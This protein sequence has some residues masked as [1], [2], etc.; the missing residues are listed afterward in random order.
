MKL[1]LNHRT[2]KNLFGGDGE[3]YLCDIA[4]SEMMHEKNRCFLTIRL[5]QGA[6]LGIHQHLHESEIYFVLQGCG[7][8]TDHDETYEIR[9]GEAVICLD[10]DKHGIFNQSEEDLV[11]VALV[12][13][14]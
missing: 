14:S 8:Y 1:S 13:R 10:G 4:S 12:I 9:A 6:S 11:F 2:V 5:E 7:L 3:A